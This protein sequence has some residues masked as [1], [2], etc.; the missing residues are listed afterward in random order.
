[1]RLRLS[2]LVLIDCYQ[3]LHDGI[4]WSTLFPERVRTICHKV[5]HTIRKVQNDMRN[6][7]DYTKARNS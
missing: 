4:Q 1:M 2:C 7:Q 6:M 5:V 3:L